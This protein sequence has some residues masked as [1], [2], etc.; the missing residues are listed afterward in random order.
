MN[1]REKSYLAKALQSSLARTH[2]LQHPDLEVTAEAEAEAEAGEGEERIEDADDG[3][4]AAAAEVPPPTPPAPVQA[5]PASR[6]HE[7]EICS[8]LVAENE[9]LRA[10]VES[11]IGREN[12][13]AIRKNIFSGNRA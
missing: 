11:N 3:A 5:A 13:F 9:R 2:K 1:V 10:E 4:E 8:R 12:I 6:L 7:S